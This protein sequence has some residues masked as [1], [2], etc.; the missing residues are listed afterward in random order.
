MFLEHN[1]QLRLDGDFVSKPVLILFGTQSGN[2]ED[3][4]SQLAKSA[5]SH[6]LDPK[7]VDM[8]AATVE[9][10]AASER[11]L[12]ICSTWG[13]GEMPD[14]AEA[15][16]DSIS[17]ESA[18][19]MENTHF[20]VCALGDTS[21]EFFC[22][23]G[24]D[25]DT[26]LEELG[27]KRVF[28]RK[29]CDVDFDEPYAEWAN[30][31]LPAISSVGGESVAEVATE[32]VEEVVEATSEGESS[33]EIDAIMSDG[34]RKLVILFGSQ[35]GN[36]EDLAFRTKS[37]ASSFGLNAEVHDMEGFDLGSLTDTS[38]LIII[39]STW[40]EGDMPDSAE[41][42]WQIASSDKKPKLTKTHF[43]VCALG[44]TSY[45]FFCQSGKDWDGAIES[46]GGVR[47][48]D[49]VDCDVDFDPPYEQWIIPTLANLASVDGSGEY[50]PELVTVFIEL[51]KGTSGKESVDVLDTP[52]ISRPPI[53]ISF[54]LFRYNPEIMENGWD[55]LDCNMP[56]HFS[57]LDALDKIKSDI[58]PTLSFRRNGPL[59]GVLVN[60]AVV[61]A[62]R[63]RL[64]DLVRL[65]GNSLK[66]EPL[67]GYQI[68][69]DLVVSTRNFDIHRSKSKPWMVP[70][71]RAAVD[72]VSGTTI[73]MM[74]ISEA[75]KLHVLGDVDSPQL[76]QSFSDTL[77]YDSE[78]MGPA[79]VMH[80]WKRIN[81]RRSSDKSIESKINLLQNDGG[82]WNE[83]DSSVFSRQGEF[84]KMISNSFNECRSELIRKK[85]FSG[86][87]GR[88]VKWYGLSV[89]WSG[90]VNETTLYRQVLGPL[91]LVSNLFSGV[92]MRMML[93]FTRTGAKPFR[94]VFPLVAP[95]AG[96]GKIPP[97]INS[98]VESH[99]E[100]VNLFNKLD[101]RF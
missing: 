33:G 78:Y 10:M 3:L 88:L 100:V 96:I 46:M 69:K 14:A 87:H 84:G 25:W 61:R 68:V 27:A 2:S 64:I 23:S 91:G 36:S 79:L 43:S 32:S 18:P 39:C 67:P 76:L 44:D 81:D 65:C 74:E 60:G 70:A 62:D 99:H 66:I 58:D 35:S 4:A 8:E 28:P 12:I 21:Y 59:S 34:D 1:V 29:D 71:T 51:V 38:R 17:E 7:V 49:R 30:G 31:A 95:P 42:L 37:K 13:E 41:A 50:H 90:K 97:M 101:K 73:G 6:G 57:I 92:S 72:T 83:T 53:E 93:G 47:I 55:T 48:Y 94:S 11:I 52:V 80:A 63:S 9:Q 77:S 45:E 86:K 54:K 15:L 20:S 24:I 85:G 19:R 22:Q 82:A 89:K 5:P 40:G 26:R 75:T 16:W 98:K 56:G